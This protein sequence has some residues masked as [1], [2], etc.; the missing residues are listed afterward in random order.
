ME[1]HMVASHVLIAGA[2]PGGGA[3]ARSLRE[4]GYRGR[5]TLV[6][7]DQHPPYLRPAL[8]KQFLRGEVDR[9]AVLLDPDGWF[10]E[11]DVETRL[12]AWVADIDPRTGNGRLEDG[13]TVD[14]DTVILATGS[15]PR[16]LPVDGGGF[17]GVAT[18]R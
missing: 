7:G 8:S 4:R 1:D 15:I 18:P 6:G 13:T 5:I 11:H 14:S 10:D 2:G 16:P 12:D 3:A 9:S 17:E